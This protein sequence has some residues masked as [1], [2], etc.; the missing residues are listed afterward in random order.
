MKLKSSDRQFLKNSPDIRTFFILKY[1]RESEN[2]VFIFLSFRLLNFLYYW[3]LHIL[4]NLPS[5][6]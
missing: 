2:K 3:G 6:I 5:Y 1:Q 4:I